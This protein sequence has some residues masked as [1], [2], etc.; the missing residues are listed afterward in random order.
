MSKTKIKLLGVGAIDLLVNDKYHIYIDA[1]NNI[2]NCPVLNEN[3]LIIFTH[4]DGDHFSVE[5][6][7]STYQNN[8]IIGPPS[9]VLPLVRTG[10]IDCNNLI[11]DYPEQ[12]YSPKTF[13]VKDISVSIF[14]SKHFIDWNPIHCSYLLKIGHK[15]IWITGDS[16]FEP[17]FLKENSLD[18]IICNL[19]DKGFITKTDDPKHAVHHHISYLLNIL[20]NTKADKIIANHLIGF[21]GTIEPKTLKEV[22]ERYGFNKI[23]VPETTS[24]TFEV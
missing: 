6:L 17:S 22:I 15:K 20:S 18:C 3:D 5:S 24:E 14:Q 12:A 19:V 8:T 4:A 13:S 7:L 23:I 2:N 9:I 1:F 21:D 10:K 16:I 11:I